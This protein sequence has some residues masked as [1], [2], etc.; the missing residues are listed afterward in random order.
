[1][2]HVYISR[3]KLRNN[4]LPYETQIEIANELKRSPKRIQADLVLYV[5]L[6]I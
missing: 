5:W 6:Y 3:L 1:M 2:L 4:Y